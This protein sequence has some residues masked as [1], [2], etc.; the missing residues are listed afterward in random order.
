MAHLPYHIYLITI[1]TQQY[2]HFL[3]SNV[4]YNVLSIEIVV[5]QYLF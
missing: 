2:I 4:K 3:I 1:L 5:L